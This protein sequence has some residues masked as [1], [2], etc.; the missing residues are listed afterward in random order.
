MASLFLTSLCLDVQS[1]GAHLAKNR[2][3]T[4]TRAEKTLTLSSTST[5][6]KK[7]EGEIVYQDSVCV[8][9]LERHLQVG[10]SRLY[11][12]YFRLVGVYQRLARHGQF[13]N[14][15]LRSGRGEREGEGEKNKRRLDTVRHN[16][17]RWLTLK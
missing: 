6:E 16:S 11:F 9:A 3:F 4:V 12:V 8:S 15:I 2:C 17:S 13:T 5:P 10:Q 7:K 14:V 1:L